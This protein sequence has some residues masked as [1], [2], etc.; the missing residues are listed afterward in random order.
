MLL[1]DVYNI[2]HMHFNS[3][4]Y[5]HIYIWSIFM[6]RVLQTEK[7]INLC[8]SKLSVQVPGSVDQWVFSMYF[9]LPHLQC[10]CP[11]TGSRRVLDFFFEGL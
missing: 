3:Y 1:K 10:S 2:L 5:I 11:H 6:L 4:R 8:L 9:V 7:K